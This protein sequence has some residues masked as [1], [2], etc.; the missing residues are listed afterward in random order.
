MTEEKK[1]RKWNLSLVAQI[2]FILA[3]LSMV[4]LGINY[5]FAW[6][7]WSEGANLH[8]D[9]YGLTN[10]LTQLHIP[11]T[12]S[13]YINTRLSAISPYHRYDLMGSQNGN[14]PDNRM[15]WGQWPIII[16]R[17]VG[18]LT[19]NT[20]YDE[21]RLLG[22]SLSAL[23]DSLSLIVLFFLALRLMD[24]KPALL[25][26]S[27]SALCVLQLQQSHFMTVDTFA[28]L[29]SMITIYACVRI[30]QTPALIRLETG[31]LS[32]QKL[33]INHSI[34]VWLLLFSLGYGMAVASKV[35]LALLGGLLP[36]AVFISIAEI[37]LRYRQ[38]ITTIV[39]KIG[40]LALFA[41]AVT[42]FVFRL[43]Q[44]MSFR[45]VSGDTNLLTFHLNPDWT[46]SMAV[47]QSE[48]SGV[49]GGPPA[50]QWTHRTAIV[51]PL[52]N[53]VFWGMGLPLGITAWLGVLTSF[54][55]L[56]KQRLNWR[57]HLV[58]LVWA[59]VFFLF[60]G[61]RWV[62]S[63]RYFLPI[64]PLLCLYASWIL[65]YFI[66]KSKMLQN[67]WKPFLQG[68]SAV[69]LVVVMLGTGLWASAFT[70]AVYVNR[71]TRI[72][73][74]EWMFA[75]IP[76][77]VNFILDTPEGEIFVPV[78][79]PDNFT[80]S[81]DLV[82]SQSTRS[83]VKGRIVGVFIPRLDGITSDNQS[84]LQVKFYDLENHIITL[85]VSLVDTGQQENIRLDIIDPGE[86]LEVE[87]GQPLSVELT[88]NSNDPVTLKKIVLSNESWD[89]GLPVRLNLWDPFS[90][91]Y[92]GNSMEV[93]WMDDENKKTMFLET[94]NASDYVIVP[95]QRAIWASCRMPLMY[96]M[97]MAYYRSLFNG[98]LGFELVAEFQAPM[99]LGPLQVSDV[100]GTW[101]IGKTPALPVF[102]YNILAAEEAFSVYDHPPVWIF[103]KTDSF[104]IE[105]VKQI[106]DSVDLSQVVVQSPRD[107]TYFEVK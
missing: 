15:R 26:V 96:P 31:S 33:Q 34:W 53:M 30:A 97:T 51:F 74:T 98:D 89:E 95:S 2:L 44:P 22:R 65:F 29:F 86:A 56:Y 106:L 103:K 6:N 13:D 9:E 48:S 1:Q 3:C 99:I 101:A 18:E 70:K 72:L 71:H 40:L 78:A 41:V 67:S 27:L 81:K 47:A 19:D 84:A 20:G 85:P 52:I 16:I 35:N 4:Y 68:L 76:G 5:R 55:L 46:D 66:R 8:P 63:M 88:S 93:R 104:N 25:A 77:A 37:Q 107:A 7:N 39:Y 91:L 62:K 69:G 73:T 64:Y 45:A 102:N 80:I 36:L 24:W 60:M 23:A 21:I 90:Q 94:L 42:F 82:F 61:T 28:L 75:H 10:T 79:V 58:P 100:G 92:L 12:F 38:D 54:W 50:E 17:S 105:K 43:T 49:G 59:S 32:S 83:P 87:E 11:E 57:V 14:G